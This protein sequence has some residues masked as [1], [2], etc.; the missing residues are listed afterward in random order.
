MELD[1]EFFQAEAAKL[2]GYCFTKSA[3]DGL[4]QTEG[5]RAERAEVDGQFGR[6]VERVAL[7]YLC[8]R[9][10]AVLEF[11]ARSV[12][13]ETEALTMAYALLAAAL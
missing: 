12:G 10:G 2:D 1:R 7:R 4:S 5:A 6:K 3:Y 8:I 13:R 9:H 11:G